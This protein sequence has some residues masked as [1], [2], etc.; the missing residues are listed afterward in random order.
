MALIQSKS[1][2]LKSRALDRGLFQRQ[3][4]LGH[5]DWEGEQFIVLIFSQRMDFVGIR[6]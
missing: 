6:K 3:T 5:I 2:L 4:S 1:F